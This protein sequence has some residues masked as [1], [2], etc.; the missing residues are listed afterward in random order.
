MKWT[1]TVGTNFLK[2]KNK[3]CQ[4]SDKPSPKLT[5]EPTLHIRHTP[6]NGYIHHNFA[7]NQ[8]MHYFAILIKVKR[9]ANYAV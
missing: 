6:Y 5:V 4:Q 1:P 9:D 7:S 8:P 2:Y 3:I